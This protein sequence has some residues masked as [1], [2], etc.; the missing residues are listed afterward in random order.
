MDPLVN[1]WDAIY[2]QAGNEACPPAQVLAENAFLLP[3]NGT[4]LDLAC[5]LGGNA[6]FLARQGLAVTAIDIS[7]V[8]IEKLT[9]HAA[10]QGLDIN[11]SQQKIDRHSLMELRFDVIVVSRFLDRNL[12]DAIIGAL[13]PAGLLFYQTYTRKKAG[14]HG[15]NNPDYL[16]AES[17]LLALFSPLRPVFYR[18]NGLI[19]NKMMGLRGE[20][21]FIGQKYA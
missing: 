13:N 1:K 17:E 15:P 8:A 16:L 3:E 2:S 4:A 18:D 20:A 12:S 14:R 5:G 10:L 7:S 11:A 9:A 6:I 21:Q 19:G